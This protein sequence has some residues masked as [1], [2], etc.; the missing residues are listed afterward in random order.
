MT[1]LLVLAGL[2][3]AGLVVLVVLALAGR[4]RGGRK[5][6]DGAQRLAALAAL[7]QVRLPDAGQ[8]RPNPYH[9]EPHTGA[10]RVH[11]RARPESS[12]SG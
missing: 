4:R 1:T 12:G 5:P 7:T 2:V 11:H 6:A 10:V 8:T 3:T 9:H